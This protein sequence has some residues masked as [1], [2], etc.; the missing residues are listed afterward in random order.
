LKIFFLII[1]NRKV[2]FQLKIMR[3]FVSLAFLSIF[4]KEKIYRYLKII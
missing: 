3:N 4:L 1:N 2:D